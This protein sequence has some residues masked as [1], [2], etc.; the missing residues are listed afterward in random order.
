MPS[1]LPATISWKPLMVSASLT[2]LPGTPVNCSATLQ[3]GRA[4]H[5]RVGQLDVFARH[6]RELLGHV[7]GLREEALDLARARNG[8]L[9]LVRQLV[10]AQDGDDVLQ[11]F[12]ALQHALHVLQD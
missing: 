4:V 11:I 2:Y 3:R 5:G 1:C 7:E 9:V 10:D 6:A 12:V 8:E